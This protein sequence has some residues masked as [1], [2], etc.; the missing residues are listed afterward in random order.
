[1]S[2]VP[3]TGTPR[4]L[5]PGPNHTAAEQG[6]AEMFD[7]IGANLSAGAGSRNESEQ[8]FPGIRILDDLFQVG[9]YVRARNYIDW[10][11]PRLEET[12][13]RATTPAP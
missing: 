12:A 5:S 3:H 7:A 10:D 1:M 6:V 9:A 8:V 13:A 11:M 4:G 2:A